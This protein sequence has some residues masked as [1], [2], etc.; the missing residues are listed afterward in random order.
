MLKL[1]ELKLA[2][3]RVPDPRESTLHDSSDRCTGLGTTRNGRRDERA[4]QHQGVRPSA[5]Q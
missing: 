1:S 5:I 2:Q 4:V 3:T